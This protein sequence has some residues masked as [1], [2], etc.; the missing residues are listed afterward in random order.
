MVDHDTSI[1][2]TSPGV[3]TCGDAGTPL[4][5][6][7]AGAGSVRQ[8]AARCPTANNPQVVRFLRMRRSLNQRQ[9]VGDKQR[10]NSI[11]GLIR[12]D[13]RHRQAFFDLDD[14]IIRIG[15]PNASEPAAT[16]SAT[17]LLPD[18]IRA[19]GFTPRK[20]SLASSSPHAANKQVA[21][22]AVVP[23]SGL[24]IPHVHTIVDR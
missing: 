8:P 4:R 24:A 12:V 21:C 19:F 17:C 23:N 9:R 14:G 20:K 5:N 13:D 11:G 18:M 10:S 1:A 2:R 16:A 6:G 7:V 3:L 22:V 15:K